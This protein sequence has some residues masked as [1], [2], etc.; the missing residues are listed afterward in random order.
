MTSEALA[1]IGWVAF[2]AVAAVLAS[3]AMLQL[4]RLALLVIG[5]MTRDD[6]R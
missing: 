6:D 4:F 3:F 1:M 5:C 2:V